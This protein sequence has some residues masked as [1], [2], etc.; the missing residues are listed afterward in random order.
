ML[1]CIVLYR[2]VLY[3]IV[4]CIV[5]H[6]IVF[7]DL[8]PRSA[9][10]F[11]VCVCVCASQCALPLSFFLT[12]S[13]S[14]S[15]VCEQ[16]R[17][18]CC[19][20]R[21]RARCIARASSRCCRPSA[22]GRGCMRRRRTSCISTRRPPRGWS[23]GV[24]RPNKR[25][26][27]HTADAHL[28]VAPLR[29]TSSMHPV[30]RGGVRGGVQAETLGRDHRQGRRSRR[31]LGEVDCSESHRTLA[32]FLSVSPFTSLYLS[33]YQSILSLSLVGGV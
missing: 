9:H 22:S 26:S 8:H 21:P 20:S 3:C 28:L 19:S 4:Y 23:A 7:V 24:R 14:L 31:G 12:P 10:V 13:V 2:S 33:V 17:A 18:S 16:V 29:N 32:L 15:S 30:G 11:A 25:T 5:L 1:Y 6:C 27:S